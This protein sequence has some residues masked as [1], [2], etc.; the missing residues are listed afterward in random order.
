M[1][2]SMHFIKVYEKKESKFYLK[3]NFLLSFYLSQRIN[4]GVHK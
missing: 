1:A 4:K 3:N 2:Q